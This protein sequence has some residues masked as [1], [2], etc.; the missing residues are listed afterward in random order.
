VE[1]LE[2]MG[3][4]VDREE[5]DS[6]GPEP[7]GILTVRHAG[8]EA[9][10]V[11]AD[12]VPF[13][14]DELPLVGV[15]GGLA[16]G[17]TIVRGASELRVKE[18]D[19]IAGLVAGLRSL[20]A[21]AEELPDG[22]RVTGARRPRGGIVDPQGDHRLAMAFAVAALVADGP[23]AIEGVDSISDSYPGFLQTLDS[24]R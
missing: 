16:G 12:E 13:L 19:R 20:G 9:V 6:Q 4:Q 15:L 1:L 21:D 24:L 8:L 17:T 5:A 11:S 23:V 2:R 22:F 7:Y 14:I 10:E 18:S 3:A